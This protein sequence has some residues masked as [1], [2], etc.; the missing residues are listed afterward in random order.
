[1]ELEKIIIEIAKNTNGWTIVLIFLIYVGYH[2]YKSYREDIAL[3]FSLEI[4]KDTINTL[5]G[6]IDRNIHI[7]SNKVELFINHII[8]R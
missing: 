1:M 7:L 3:K 2:I 8:S 6:N 5:L 4:I